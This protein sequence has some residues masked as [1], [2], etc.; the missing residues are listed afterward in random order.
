[1]LSITA[2]KRSGA[3][4]SPVSSRASL[5]TFSAGDTPTSQNPVGYHH[6]P[7]GRWIIRISSRSLNAHAASHRRCDVS[8][9]AG[10]HLLAPSAPQCFRVGVAPACDDRMHS[11][12]LFEQFLVAFR[13]EAVGL[14]RKPGPR[15][16]GYAFNKARQFGEQI[17]IRHR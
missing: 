1:L 4:T 3:M 8:L 15:D 9:V 17:R 14:E 7:A 6:L 5:A 16:R 13:V 11:R 2:I 10:D 12:G